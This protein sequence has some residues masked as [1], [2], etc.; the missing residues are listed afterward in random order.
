MRQQLISESGGSTQSEIQSTSIGSTLV[1]RKDGNLRSLT[2][3]IPKGI[4]IK[5]LTENKS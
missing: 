5:Y 3:G 2:N 1:R 4:P